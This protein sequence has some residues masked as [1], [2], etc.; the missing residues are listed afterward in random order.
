MVAL[1]SPDGGGIVYRS[2]PDQDQPQPS[3]SASRQRPGSPPMVRA[4][5][6]IAGLSRGDFGA[7]SAGACRRRAGG[8]EEDGGAPGEGADTG[9]VNR[10][11]SPERQ[12]RTAVSEYVEHYHRERNHQGLEN[13]LIEPAAEAASGA[14]KVVRESRLVGL[15]NHYRRAA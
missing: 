9:V 1:S 6:N 4:A 2:Y 14:G 3:I 11:A 12:L 13:R 15:L 5:Q 10:I 8:V 7:K